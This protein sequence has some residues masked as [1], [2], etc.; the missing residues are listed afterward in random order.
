MAKFVLEVDNL[1]KVFKNRVAVDNVS[2]EI[3][4]G[5]IFGL[6]GPNGA[7]KTTIIRMLTGLAEPTSGEIYIDGISLRKHFEKAIAKLGGIIETPELY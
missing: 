4:K 5:E 7:G 3:I 1:T 6:I 2:F